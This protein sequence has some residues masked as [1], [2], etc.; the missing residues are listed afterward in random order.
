MEEDKSSPGMDLRTS[1]QILSVHGDWQLTRPFLVSGRYAAKWSGDQ[2]NG[3]STKYRAQVVGTRA[4]WEFAPKWDVGFVASMLFS[5]GMQSKQYGVGLE[6]GYLAAQN[7]WVSAGY[8]F[9]GYK[10]ADMAGA[11]YTAKGPYVRLRYKFDESLLD[12][13]DNKKVAK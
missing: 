10:D 9:F 6:L 3:I 2:S 8:N 5:N 12:G 7:L 13:A 4:T 1:T 11:D